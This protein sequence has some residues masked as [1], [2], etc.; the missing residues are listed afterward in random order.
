[1]RVKIKEAIV[2]E[3]KYDK[4]KLS[5]LVDGVI[6]ETSGFHIFQDPEQLALIRRLADTQGIILLTDSD[7][8]GFVIRNYLTGAIDNR[9]IKQAYIPDCYGKEK[10]K[11]SFSK[12]GKLG[13]EGMQKEVLLEALRRAGATFLEETA[14]EQGK[15]EPITKAELFALGI[16]GGEHSGQK[17]KWL[18]RQLKLPERMTTNAMLR[19]V[20]ETMERERF[21]ALAAQYDKIA[22][23]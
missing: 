3:G 10:R 13:V 19:V 4:I 14:P 8:A 2:V 7:G 12:E 23:S 21:F 15:R 18:L 22:N 17:R 20:N 5:S 16:T 1:M 11:A 9:K 6:L